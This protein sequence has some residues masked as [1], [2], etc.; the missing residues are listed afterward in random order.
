MTKPLFFSRA[1]IDPIEAHGRSLYRLFNITIE[2]NVI[3]RQRGDSVEALGFRRALD[4]LRENAVTVADWRL[5][6][7]RV[8]ALNPE[9]IST[10][11]SA[12]RIYGTKA[13]VAEFNHARLRDLH[14]PVLKVLASHEGIKAAE[15]TS[16]EAD[17]LHA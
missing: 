13:R 9:E 14:C 11:D 15:A 16:D 12:L 6:T 2:L 17:N 10:F 7:S 4:A 8:A 1:L 5:L 3:C